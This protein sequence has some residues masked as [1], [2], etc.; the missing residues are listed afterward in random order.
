MNDYARRSAKF[1]LYIVIIFFIVL[2]LY[3][4]L[5]YGKPLSVSMQEMISNTRFVTLFG[6]LMVYGLLYPMVAFVNHK[7][8]LNGSYDENRKLIEKVFEKLDYVKTEE[9][10]GYVAFRKKSAMARLVQWYEDKIAINTSTNPL[11]INGFRKRVN[12]IDRLIDIEI[13][14]RRSDD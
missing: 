2:G 9:G 14:N 10:P 12:R 1:I 13:S 11:I 7:R 3:P 6:L 4:L 5:K 8:Y